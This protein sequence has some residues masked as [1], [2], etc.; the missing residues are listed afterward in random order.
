MGSQVEEINQHGAGSVLGIDRHMQSLPGASV[1]LPFKDLRRIGAASRVMVQVAVGIMAVSPP[2]WTRTVALGF[3]RQKDSHLKILRGR[4]GRILS[5]IVALGGGTIGA[6]LVT[7]IAVPFISRSYT[8]AEFGV[9]ALASSLSSVLAPVL[10]LRLES[11]MLLPSSKRQTSA[12]FFLA[13]ASSVILSVAASLVLGIMQLLGTLASNGEYQGFPIWVGLISF[14]SALFALVGQLALRQ[15][16]YG[17]VAQRSVTQSLV[18]NGTQVGLGFAG[19][20]SVGLMAGA[21]FGRVVGIVPLFLASRSELSHFSKPDVLAMLK[22]Y[23]RFPTI[24]TLSGLLN[25]FGLQAP[26]LFAGL[27]FSASQVGQLGMAERILFIPIT[28]VGGAIAQVLEAEVAERLRLQTG[29]ILRV[30]L[31]LSTALASVSLLLVILVMTLAQWAV[32]FLLGAKWQE[33]S[34]LMTLLVIPVATR[35]V[36]SPMSRVLMSLQH[37]RI[38]LVLDVVRV[39]LILVAALVVSHFQIGF[40]WAMATLYCGLGLTYVATWFVSLHVVR[41]S[42]LG[43]SSNPRPAS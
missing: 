29:G 9:F 38:T 40:I 31:R 41:R 35:L 26:V 23:W 24:F 34:I 21:T 10:T 19:A 7:L 25:A 17:A 27:W 30:F 20:T 42:P 5:G 37:G 18:I 6:Q 2:G 3:H 28:V 14:L 8:P 39:A 36:A 22:E 4:G 33:A 1:V 32:P 11:A 12:I 13:L 16:R 15:H 43:A